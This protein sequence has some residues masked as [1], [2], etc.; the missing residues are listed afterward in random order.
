MDKEINIKIDEIKSRHY[1][2]ENFVLPEFSQCI[3]FLILITKYI[4]I[5]NFRIKGI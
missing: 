5:S 3:I 4:F 1:L 2:K